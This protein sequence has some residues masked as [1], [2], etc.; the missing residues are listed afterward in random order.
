[1]SCRWPCPRTN[2][3]RMGTMMPDL[4]PSKRAT[5][6]A[7]RRLDLTPAPTHDPCPFHGPVQNQSMPSD[8]FMAI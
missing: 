5:P 8:L 3:M 2:S 1:M 7:H 6:S 4:S